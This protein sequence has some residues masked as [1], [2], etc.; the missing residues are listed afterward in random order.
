MEAFLFPALPD[1]LH[2]RVLRVYSCQPIAR[3]L[4]SI[5]NSSRGAKKYG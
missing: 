1:D 5:I 2:L 3:N 4:R